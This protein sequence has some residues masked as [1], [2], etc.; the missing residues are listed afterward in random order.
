VR[1][2]ARRLTAVPDE[3]LSQNKGEKMAAHEHRET[4]LQVLKMTVFKTN[5][6]RWLV[7]AAAMVGVLCEPGE[8]YCANKMPL[9]FPRGNG[10]KMEDAEKFWNETKFEDGHLRIFSEKSSGAS[11]ILPPKTPWDSML[12]R[13][14]PGYWVK[15]LIMPGRGKWQH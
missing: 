13:R 9:T 8:Y 4:G 3:F 10:P 14:H 15:P 5:I 7:A 6:H 12:P 1:F 2:V 11:T